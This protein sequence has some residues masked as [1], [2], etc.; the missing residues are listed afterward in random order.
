MAD[1]SVPFQPH[2]AGIKESS[3]L[4]KLGYKLNFVS[5]A[6]CKSGDTQLGFR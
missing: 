2:L 4:N 5:D 3:V 6:L 1:L